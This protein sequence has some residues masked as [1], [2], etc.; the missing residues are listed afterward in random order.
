MRRIAAITSLL[1]AVALTEAGKSTAQ[2]IGPTPTPT[3]TQTS[4]PVTIVNGFCFGG[5]VVGVFPCPTSPTQRELLTPTKTMSV[6]GPIPGPFDMT[7]YTVTITTQLVCFPLTSEPIDVYLLANSTSAVLTPLT[8]FST[9]TGT[10]ATVFV[11]PDTGQAQLLLEVRNKIVGRGGVAI[12]AVWPNERL[13]Q[14]IT[15]IPPSPV[16]T[17]PGTPATATPTA[18]PGTPTATPVSTATPTPPF[19]VRTCVSPNVMNGR[20]LGGQQATIYGQTLPGA[21]CTPNVT[22][23]PGPTH[24]AT[25]ELNYGPQV[26][27]SDG[28]VVFPFLENTL[29]T[30]GVASVTC[31]LGGQT[32]KSCAGFVVLQSDT[33]GDPAVLL[34]QAE[35]LAAQE[36]SR[37]GR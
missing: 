10:A 3:S 14:I 17:T 19:F 4:V 8:P 7:S 35:A 23:F 26:A 22:Y 31:S 28:F 1:L 32:L 29:G 27:L 13:E 9:S 33:T 15:V 21:V 24:P 6:S 37:P 2:T 36:C 20:T 12:K 11:S 18:V 25:G 16:P 34:Q 5:P 30:S